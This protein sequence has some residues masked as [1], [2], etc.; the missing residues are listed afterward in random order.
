MALPHIQNS[1]AGVNRWDAIF[2]NKFEVTIS[3]PAALQQ[4]FGGDVAII[5][6][7]VKKISGLGTLDKGVEV[8]EQTFHGSTRSFLKSQVDNTSHDIEITFELNLRNGTDN[9]VYKLFKAWNRL[10]YDNSTGETTLKNDY[11]ADWLKIR[12]AN[13]AND[14]YREVVYKDIMLKEGLDFQNELDYTNADIVTDF[15]VKFRSD[16]AQEQNA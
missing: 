4:E 11:C 8:S 7:Q 5:S 2:V 14:V 16:W 6:E 15:V 13:R 10:C 3:I 12:I 9:F 1:Q